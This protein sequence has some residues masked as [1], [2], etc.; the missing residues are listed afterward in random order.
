MVRGVLLLALAG[1]LAGV[2]GGA[3]S[4]A[5]STHR[6]VTA[7]P[8]AL[9][10]VAQLQAAIAALRGSAP[11]GSP[12]ARHFVVTGH[13]RNACFREG[14]GPC[15]AVC[16]YLGRGATSAG[17]PCPAMA[18]AGCVYFVAERPGTCA[19]AAPPPR[20]SFVPRP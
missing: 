2:G 6:P 20:L 17:T 15:I 8:A 5:G 9:V 4:G 11:A 14:G 1:G 16:S 10:S 12:R 18:P 7:K 3:L 19:P 13:G